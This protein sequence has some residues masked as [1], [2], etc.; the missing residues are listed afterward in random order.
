MVCTMTMFT[1]ATPLEESQSENIQSEMAMTDTA[2]PRV[3]LSFDDASDGERFDDTYWSVTEGH[4]KANTA[5]GPQWS[6]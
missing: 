5:W 3:K 2:F 6:R 4:W 1:D